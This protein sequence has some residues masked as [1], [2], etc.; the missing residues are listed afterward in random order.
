[1][2]NIQKAIN[3]IPVPDP[4]FIKAAKKMIPNSKRARKTIIPTINAGSAALKYTF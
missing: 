4:S 3:A 1:M 2:M